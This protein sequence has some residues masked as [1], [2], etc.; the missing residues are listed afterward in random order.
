M[1][2]AI[3]AGIVIQNDDP[4]KAGRVKVFIPGITNTVY[5][6]WNSDSTDKEFSFIDGSI[7]PIMDQLQQDLP[8]ADCGTGLFGG[9]SSQ[10]M[11]GDTPTDLTQP[12]G[13]FSIPSVGSHVN[14]FFR[15]GNVRFPV[16]FT[17][18]HGATEWAT[19]IG[20]DYPVAGTDTNVH[21]INSS[22]HGFRFVDTS[23]REEILLKHFSGSSV[24]MLLKDSIWNTVENKTETV[25][26]D[27]T[28]TVGNN[29][30]ATAGKNVTIEVGST[31]IKIDASGTVEINAQTSTTITT[32]IATING[33]LQVN[34][35]ITSSTG[36]YAPIIVGS[37]SVSSPSII[38]TSMVVAGVE[39]ALHTHLYN[40][41]PGSP[42]PTA[43]AI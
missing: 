2:V 3:Y 21:V 17:G 32:P 35:T 10:I 9:D 29:V 27:F 30:I 18:S 13:L 4:R 37:A 41:G 26:T 11:I 14:V 24:Q 40:P 28:L 34:G 1:N 7:I 38:G 20:D 22:K 36:I 31:T 15:D 25:G 39:M 33:N 5:D 42:T 16:Y 12:A 8:W 43:P 23:D 19:A 6:G